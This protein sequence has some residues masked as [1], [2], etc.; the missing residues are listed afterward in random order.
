MW[1]ELSRF[2]AAPGE[3]AA[4]MARLEAAAELAWSAD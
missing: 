1:R 2:L 4:T 3:V